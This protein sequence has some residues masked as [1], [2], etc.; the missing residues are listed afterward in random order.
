VHLLL[1]S[2]F[3][4]GNPTNNIGWDT[5]R[6]ITQRP[7]V[8]WTI[9]LSLGDSHSG[10]RVLGTD[11]GY[12]EHVRFG[13]DRA[14]ELVHGAAFAD[15]HDAVLAADVADALGYRPG[16]ALVIAQGAADV[17]LSLH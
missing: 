7:E 10:F 4:I 9:P 5:Y 6:T 8:A 1:Y 15:A 3:R 11:R 12:I 17:S 13:R 16:D 2:V 14:L